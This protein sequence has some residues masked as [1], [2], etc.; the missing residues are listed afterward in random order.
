MIDEAGVEIAD[1][2]HMASGVPAEI[3]GLGD[4]FGT[5]DIGR[6]ASLT[7]L[8]R[9]LRAHAVIVAGALFEQGAA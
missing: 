5:V 4:Q 6:L 2:L 9:H 7:C 1:A 8:D 3:L